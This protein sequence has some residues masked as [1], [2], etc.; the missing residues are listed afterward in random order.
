MEF[1]NYYLLNISPI[2]YLTYNAIL[3]LVFYPHMPIGKVWIYVYCLCV[4]DF[5][6]LLVCLFNFVCM[7]TDFSADDKASDVTFCTAVHRRPRQ[8]IFHFG[9][10]CS[11]RSPKYDESATARA[12]PTGCKHYPTDAPT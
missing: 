2:T 8:G 12:T 3:H 7:V 9:E 6:C 5:V 10:L 11:P 1:I 4:C